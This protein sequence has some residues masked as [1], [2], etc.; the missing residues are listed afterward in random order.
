VTSRPKV[1]RRQAAAIGVLLAGVT[2]TACTGG[3]S[4]TDGTPPGGSR[5]PAIGNGSATPSTATPTTTAAPGTPSAT[6]GPA[7]PNCRT[8]WGTAEKRHTSTE[9]APLSGIRAGEHPCYDRLVFD[10]RAPG[11][12][13]YIVRYVPTV[14][15]DGSGTPIP[16]RGG[17]RL[18][19]VVQAP[20]Y[21]NQNY[22]RTYVVRNQRELV[23]VTGWRTF[24]QVVWAGSFEGQTTVGLG[25]RTTLPFRVMVVDGPGSGSRIVVDVAHEW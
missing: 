8:S 7:A 6:G 20:A 21:E 16:L 5:T 18:A 13:G 15:E 24:R 19:V 9:V 25:V 23:N 14:R 11:A 4:T 2:A 12:D 1:R 22:L 3:T 17:A 10:V